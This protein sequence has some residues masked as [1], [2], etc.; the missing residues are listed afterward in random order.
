MYEHRSLNGK[1]CV[2]IT[3]SKALWYTNDGFLSLT[4]VP[5]IVYHA[6]Y[7]TRLVSAFYT[8]HSQ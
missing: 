5:L 1:I 4:V 6:E 7:G 8:R 2:L 3:T